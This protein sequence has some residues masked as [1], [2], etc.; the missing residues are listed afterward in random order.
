MTIIKVVVNLFSV[1]KL[2]DYQTSCFR[3]T[4][5]KHIRDGGWEFYF[6]FARAR[7]LVDG[8]LALRELERQSA[9]AQGQSVQRHHCMNDG[10]SDRRRGTLQ[11]FT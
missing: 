4:N 6:H 11:C 9:A 2:I 8:P 10:A 5:Q 7:V 3:K 1:S